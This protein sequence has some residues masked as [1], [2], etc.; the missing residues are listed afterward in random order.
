[1]RIDWDSIAW[2]SWW[3]RRLGLR[4]IAIE[5]NGIFENSFASTKIEWADPLIWSSWQKGVILW[6]SIERRKRNWKG[7]LGY[8]IGKG[9]VG[10]ERNRAHSAPSLSA[11]LLN[12]SWTLLSFHSF[13]LGIHLP[14]DSTL[15]NG[16]GSLACLEETR[17][18]SSFPSWR[19]WS[20]SSNP[21]KDLGR[22][23]KVIER[24]KK[25]LSLQ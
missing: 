25:E 3:K 17:Q 19:I 6:S 1:M 14:V 10:F 11:Y 5:S 4:P 15:R 22:K 23:S 18:V 24:W 7:S 12:P 20:S 9:E 8:E 2:A 21:K 16:G 13:L